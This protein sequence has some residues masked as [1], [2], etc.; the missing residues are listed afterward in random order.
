MN[1]RHSYVLSSGLLKPSYAPEMRACT[2]VMVMRTQQFNKANSERMLMCFEDC[3]V[4]LNY[5]IF[6]IS[7]SYSQSLVC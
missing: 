1:Y 5:D 3:K 4:F 2:N 6:Y 7:D